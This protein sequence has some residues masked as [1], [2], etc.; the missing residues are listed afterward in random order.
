[1]ISITGSPISRHGPPTSITRDTQR[2][3]FTR[4][5]RSSVPL[6]A[7]LSWRCSFYH[8]YDDTFAKTMPDGVIALTNAHPESKLLITGHSL[9]GSLAIFCA[10]H[11][12]KLGL[13]PQV[14]TFGQPRLGNAAFAN[15]VNKVLDAPLRFTN[16]NDVV[17]HLPLE[18]MGFYHNAQEV[19]IH[20]ADNNPLTLRYCALPPLRW[21]LTCSSRF[22]NTTDGEDP[23][24]SDSVSFPTSVSDHLDYLN[25]STTSG[26]ALGLT[27]KYVRDMP[28]DI[29]EPPK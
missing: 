22:C 1:M 11:L 16:H 18:S 15:V 23:T 27:A 2:H 29:F 10:L 9:G 6:F 24:C 13:T 5:A 12:T 25:A 3:E 17:P 21:I 26:C 8:D 7:Y 19:W 28:K 20:T 14:I 4:G